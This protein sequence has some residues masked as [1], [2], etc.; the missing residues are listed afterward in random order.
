[1]VRLMTMWF[2]PPAAVASKPVMFQSKI[3]SGLARDPKASQDL[4]SENCSCHFREISKVVLHDRSSL[5]RRVGRELDLSLSSDR[6]VL[7]ARTSWPTLIRLGRIILRTP[8]IHKADYANGLN[9][10]EMLGR[11]P[12][13]SQAR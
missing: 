5:C 10:E 6:R 7:A 8:V 1:M 4:Q 2:W 9:D 11:G 13:P 12:F 3:S